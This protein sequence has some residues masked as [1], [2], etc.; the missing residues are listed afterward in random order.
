MINNYGYDTNKFHDE[1][2]EALKIIKKAPWVFFLSNQRLKAV[3]AI[4][5]GRQWM[6]ENVSEIKE[7]N[8]T[9]WAARRSRMKHKANSIKNLEP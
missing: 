7:N 9:R 3:F 1:M 4:E 2:K 8:M 6:K 5:D